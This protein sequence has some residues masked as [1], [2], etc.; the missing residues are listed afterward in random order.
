MQTTAL[1]SNFPAGKFITIS[2]IASIWQQASQ[3]A[4]Y[5]FVVKKEMQSNLSIVP[6]V[7]IIDVPIFIIWGVWVTLFT[8]LVVFFHYL[9]SQ[10]FGRSISSCL[11]S[12]TI[13]WA[14]FYVLFWVGMAQMNLARWPFVPYVL[15]LA[16]IETIITVFIADKLFTKYSI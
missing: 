9:Y 6:N 12:G 3:F 11:L 1:K 5:W 16:W 8:M 4:R 15:V 13:S 2:L 10:K 7:A 14:F